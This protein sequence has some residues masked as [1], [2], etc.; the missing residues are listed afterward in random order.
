MGR[1]L[2]TSHTGIYITKSTKRRWHG[3]ADYVFYIVYQKNGKKK[4]EKV[5]WA[6]DGYTIKMAIA[7]R[8]KRLQENDSRFDFLKAEE[9]MMTFSE[10]WKQVWDRH[11]HI[12]KSHNDDLSRYK[13]YLEKTIGHKR[14]SEITSMDID[15]IKLSLLNELK[16]PATIVQVIGLIRRVFNFL[17][18]WD[19]WHGENPVNK[20]KMPKNDNKRLRHLTKEEV[21]RLLLDLSKRCPYTYKLA[22]MSIYTGMRVTEIM[23]LKGEHV[24]LESGIIHIVDSKSN[25]SRVAFIGRE[26]KQML[27][28][29]DMVPGRIVFERPRAHYRVSKDSYPKLSKK[30][31]EA[32]DALGFNKG[33]TD[34]RFKVV[35]HTLRH[36]FATW[37]AEKGVS[38][39]IIAMLLG[40]SCLSSTKRYAHISEKFK[41]TITDIINSFD[42]TIMNIGEGECDITND[43]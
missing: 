10:G 32:V 17:I 30:F 42:I 7:L 15:T 20:I 34:R 43:E 26:L 28:Q 2:H 27:S 12:L 33:Q 4:F 21:D 5:G 35:F 13:K 19:V 23:T 25:R 39:H 37:L 24:D 1:F 16:S 11:I 36:T 31:S 40:H 14:L 41:G 38:I 3:R 29:I 9:K 8:E 6:G 22:L 18:D